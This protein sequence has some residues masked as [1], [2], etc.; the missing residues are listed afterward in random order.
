M[1]GQRV[2][3]IRR[4]GGSAAPGVRDAQR[5]PAARRPPADV[6]AALADG[7]GLIQAADFD[8]TT[9]SRSRLHR[10]ERAGV[11]VCVAKGVYADAAVLAAGDGWAAHRLR[12]RGF[13]R[14]AA[15][16]SYASDWSSIVLHD[17]PTMGRPPA[18]PNVIRP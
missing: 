7:G 10:L 2:V 14:V 17:L 4:I 16:D 13:L 1:V 12:V 11:L 8:T 15:P 3:H 18:V 9:H 6:R 5:M